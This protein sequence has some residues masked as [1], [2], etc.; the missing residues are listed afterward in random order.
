MGD[1]CKLDLAANLSDHVVQIDDS[2]S[3]TVIWGR[4]LTGDLPPWT[5]GWRIE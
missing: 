3:G 4:E 5:L 2:S 1:G